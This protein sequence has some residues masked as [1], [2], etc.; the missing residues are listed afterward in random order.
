MT[1]VAGVPRGSTDPV[2]GSMEP[3]KKAQTDNPKDPE[4]TNF[5]C[6]RFK[7]MLSYEGATVHFVGVWFVVALSKVTL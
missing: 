6:Q 5:T 2:L 1:N 3:P 7:Q 4:Y